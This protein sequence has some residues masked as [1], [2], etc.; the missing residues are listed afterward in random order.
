MTGWTWPGGARLAVSVV[1]NVEEGA[2]LNPTDGD[3]VAE[4]VDE[5]GIALKKGLRN[6]G[7]ESNYRYGVEAGAPRVLRLLADHGIAAT[8]TAA[9][10]ALERA[11]G[12][13]PAIVAGGHEV[14]AHGWRWAP[15]HRLDEEEER[16][17][18]RR[19]TAS[20]EATTGARPVGWLSRYLHT[21]ETRRLLAAEGYLY[22]MDDYGSDTPSWDAP[23]G[24]P[25]VV[26]PYALDTND[27][28]MW[29]A[30]ALSPAD[31]AGY[32][33]DSFDW[34]MREE[35]ER[36]QMLSIGVHLR[37]IGRPGRIG[38]FERVLAHLAGRRDAWIASRRAIA[39]HFAAA[40]RP[41]SV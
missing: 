24:R 31:W 11:P 33:I 37:I 5:L 21:G 7:N 26:L 34:M 12:L 13:G 29:N 39:A 14:C 8:F 10:Q 32:A 19:A 6:W 4:P 16:A 35:P 18:I 9:A 28:K 23:G 30:P 41:P 20:I 22:H 27:M 38:A 15:Q 25:I 1:V 2:E 40:V 17:F 3:E 36:P